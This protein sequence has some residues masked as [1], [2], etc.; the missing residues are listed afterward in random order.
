MTGAMFVA[1]IEQVFGM[2]SPKKRK[3]DECEAMIEKSLNVLKNIAPDEEKDDTR[4]DAK[5]Q[6]RN[7]PKGVQI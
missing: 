2:T 6:S 1:K 7:L 5:E 4:S 3:N